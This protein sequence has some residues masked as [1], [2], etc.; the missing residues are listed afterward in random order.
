MSEAVLTAAL[1]RLTAALP[2]WRDATGS[3][4]P[5]HEGRLPAFALKVVYTDSERTGM[6]DGEWMHEG[7]L[8]IEIATHPPA[9]SESGLHD[10]ARQFVTAILTPDDD[11]G[12]VAW[13]IDQGSFEAEHDKGA[14]PISRGEILFPLTV[15]E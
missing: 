8:E 4:H 13:S 11:L 10:I 7:Q 2:D 6:G 15:I 9:Q 3:V 5:V 12:G 1:A 14:S